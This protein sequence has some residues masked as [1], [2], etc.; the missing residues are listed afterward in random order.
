MVLSDELTSAEISRP[1]V[2]EAT[3]STAIASMSSTSGSD[4]RKAPCAG[5]G[6]PSQAD[7]HEHDRL[8]GAD[9]AQDH[10]LGR[11]GRRPAT[12]RPLVP[13]CRSAVP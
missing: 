5:S 2:I 9:Q 10:D 12:A 4:V 13:W 3:A 7:Q 1:A 11:T 8:H 6:R